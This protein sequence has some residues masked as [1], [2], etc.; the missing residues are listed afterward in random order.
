MTNKRHSRLPKTKEWRILA[1]LWFLVREIQTILYLSSST[2]DL[3]ETCF[4]VRRNGRRE[5]HD[6]DHH[7]YSLHG[8][9]EQLL[10]DHNFRRADDHYGLRLRRGCLILAHRSV[11]H[12]GGGGVHHEGSP[13][14]P[15]VGQ[16]HDRNP[17][18][19]GERDHY[20]FRGTYLN[21]S[22]EL[23]SLMFV[24]FWDAMR[25]SIFSNMSNMLIAKLVKNLPLFANWVKYAR[26]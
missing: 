7:E 22:L 18:R 23:V 26:M 13:C 11:L 17:C 2:G 25:D 15:R 14:D 19:V 3:D 21:L 8:R 20:E 5:Q 12:V 4:S 6:G 24:V 16:M 1:T 9:R 10:R